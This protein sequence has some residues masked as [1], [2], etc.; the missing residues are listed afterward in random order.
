[1][2]PRKKTT[3]KQDDSARELAIAAARIAEHDNAE[4][5]VV[6][7]LRGI[8][9][10]ADFFVIATGTSDRQLRSI[11]DDL[12]RHGKNVGQKVWRT[13][14]MDTG[15]WILLDF[16]DV[17][18]HLFDD[19]HRSYYDLEMIWGECPRVEWQDRPADG[20]A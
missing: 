13:A 14:G 16:V 10:V 11:G 17:V 9:P 12:A 3:G 18:V 4:D 2:A 20:S 7:D 6:L 1:M 19:K 5:I 8:S 15:E